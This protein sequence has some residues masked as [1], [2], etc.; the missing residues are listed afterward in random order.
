VGRSL[1]RTVKPDFSVEAVITM[2]EGSY[3]DGTDIGSVGG[4]RGGGD[5]LHHDLPLTTS[6]MTAAAARI[7]LLL[8]G[9]RTLEW[10]TE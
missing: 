1:I 6:P 9:A 4:G 3:K 7:V 10:T 8:P 5:A 2:E